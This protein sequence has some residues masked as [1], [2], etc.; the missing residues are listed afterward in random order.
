MELSNVLQVFQV[1]AL[2]FIIRVNCVTYL[3]VGRVVIGRPGLID[4]DEARGTGHTNYITCVW[5]TMV[6]AASDSG[7]IEPLP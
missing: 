1:G 3:P 4:R 5:L 6:K 2:F 7:P